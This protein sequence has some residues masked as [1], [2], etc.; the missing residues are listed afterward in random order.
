MPVCQNLHRLD[1]DES[2]TDDAVEPGEEVG[3]AVGTVADF[4]DEGQIGRGLK[5]SAGMMDARMSPEAGDASRDGGSSHA[6]A[7]SLVDDRLPQR[8]A[9]VP[10]ALSDVNAQQFCIVHEIHGKFYYAQLACRL[11]ATS[12]T[13]VKLVDEG[14]LRAL[15][16]PFEV[17]T[18]RESG[19][20]IHF[21]LAV[22]LSPVPVAMFRGVASSKVGT[23]IIA[24]PWRAE[25]ARTALLLGFTVFTMGLA[26]V[27]GASLGHSPLRFI[28]ATAEM[29]LLY[30]GT[31]AARDAQLSPVL[32]Q[33]GRL[34]EAYGL[35]A[36]LASGRVAVG[37]RGHGSGMMIHAAVETHRPMMADPVAT[38]RATV[39]PDLHAMRTQQGVGMT[40]SGG[41][42]WMND[43]AT[44][45]MLT[46]DSR[47][48]EVM[49]NAERAGN[50]TSRRG[51]G[52]GVAAGSATVLYVYCVPSDG[53]SGPL[54]AEAWRLAQGSGGVALLGRAVTHMRGMRAG[55]LHLGLRGG[56]SDLL[57]R[58]WMPG[59]DDGQRVLRALQSI[60]PA[61]RQPGHP[62]SLT[63]GL[64]GGAVVVHNSMSTRELATQ[65]M[66][67][68]AGM[69]M[70]SLSIDY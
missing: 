3:D 61:A 59:N 40:W 67:A 50:I 21:P 43:S 58:A 54:F 17:Y 1:G 15:D 24:M 55:E 4:D 9:I 39:A 68:L 56:A 57:L 60:N 44:L 37:V 48:V 32:A 36:E 46:N 18:V 52:S 12:P 6:T 20:F 53:I 63:I 49:M 66:V 22:F 11:Q 19:W 69:M 27:A 7:P 23:M 38:F 35:P 64:D 28:P 70:Q 8:L 2:F 25:A 29:A 51:F 33:V 5:Q 14:G 65:L 10:I 42:A 16:Q 26:T 30:Q 34:A 41:S 47:G 13:S 31:H 62:L 45:L